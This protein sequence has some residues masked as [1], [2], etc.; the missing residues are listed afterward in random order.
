MRQCRMRSIL[1]Y[2]MYRLRSIHDCR[3]RI[4]HGFRRPLHQTNN[5]EK[6]I[7]EVYYTIEP[8]R[9]SEGTWDVISHETYERSSVLEGQPKENALEALK[10]E[11]DDLGYDNDYDQQ[12]GSLIP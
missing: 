8:S 4:E 12:G 11:D 9:H 1:R 6:V 10:G 3:F 5:T 7:T 2:Q